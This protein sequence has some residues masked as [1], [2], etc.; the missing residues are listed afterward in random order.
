MSST[1]RIVTVYG[2]MVTAEVEGT[3]RQNAVAYCQRSDGVRLMSEIIRIR[4]KL[5]DMQVFELTRG[6]KVGDPV[7]IDVIEEQH[8]RRTLEA[9]KGNQSQ[10]AKR[11]GISRSTLW[12]KMNEYQIEP[13]SEDVDDK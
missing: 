5:A 6:L 13:S 11:L 10:A 7:K 9:L 8:I 3:V 12:R 1:G 2:N 4:G